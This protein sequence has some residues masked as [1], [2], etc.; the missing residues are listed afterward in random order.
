MV[1]TYGYAVPA[2]SP[3]RR[4]FLSHTGEFRAWPPGRSFVAVAQDA[5]HRAGHAVTDMA[6]FSARDQ[7]PAEVCRAKVAE[8]DVYVGIMGF[9]CGSP[10]RDDPRVSYTEWEFE[11]ATD[12]G[13]PRL[14]FL[15]DDDALVPHRQFADGA[16][17]DRQNAFRQRVQE[18]GVTTTVFASPDQL[19]ARLFQ[20]LV[21]LAPPPAGRVGAEP[22]FTVPRRSDP[23]VPRPELTDR[24]VE[25]L[26]ADAGP[27]GLTT[28]LEGAGGFGKTTL[29][30]EV[31]WDPRVRAHFGGE[32]LWVTLGQQMPVRTW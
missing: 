15:L 12:L 17:G 26:C 11:V 32:V 8:A 24:V 20:A 14:V 23:V 30:R 21:E 4:V 18:A 28:A 7:K 1:C 5:V 3:Q 16:H 6:Y 31:G 22:L 13:L 19:E 2:A 25:R 29:A 9:R 27:V 10:V